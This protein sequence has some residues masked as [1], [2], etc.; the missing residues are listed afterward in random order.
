MYTTTSFDWWY[1]VGSAILIFSCLLPATAAATTLPIQFVD[2]LW[3]GH[4]TV[5][6]NDTVR[7]YVAL[8]N[9]ATTEITGL[10]TMYADD[11]VIDTSAVSALPGRLIETWIDWQ[12]LSAGEYRLTAQLHDIVI[13]HPN[14]PEP[15]ST[16]LRLEPKTITVAPPAPD[17]TVDLPEPDPITYRRGIEQFIPNDRTYSA[18][19]Q[20]TEQIK[21]TADWI[22]AYHATV[23]TRFTS[24]PPRPDTGTTTIGAMIFGPTI[25]WLTR[26]IQN[27][28]LGILS[29]GLW[30]FRNPI[31]IQILL[32]LGLLWLVY[33]TAKYF[34]D[35]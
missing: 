12:P 33:R 23:A 16:E 29:A 32:L 27:A 10:V 22:E 19:E 9:A 15:I 20:F 24:A 8:R 31:L 11:H 4:E 5:Q 13:Q 18:V 1:R 3:I 34:G 2:G 14:A 17:R 30:L 28:Y 6:A 26:N 7:V 21:L 25:D 35:R